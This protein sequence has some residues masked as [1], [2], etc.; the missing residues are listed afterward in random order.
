MEEL[1]KGTRLQKLVALA[2]YNR[3]NSNSYDKEAM[4]ENLSI[5]LADQRI[6][7][8]QYNYLISLIP[9][10]NSDFSKITEEIEN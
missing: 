3:I 5:L 9:I 7:K 8:E 1:K 2:A 4:I 10:D 6:V